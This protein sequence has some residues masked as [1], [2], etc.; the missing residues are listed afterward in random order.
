MSINNGVFVYHRKALEVK[1]N[2]T[3]FFAIKINRPAGDR[4]KT[5]CLEELVVILGEERVADF[6]RAGYSHYI[7]QED[8]FRQF[9]TIPLTALVGQ[10]QDKLVAVYT[11]ATLH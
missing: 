5:P 9:A 11:P 2:E 1:E 10:F 7:R 3:G 4:F 6:L 8:D